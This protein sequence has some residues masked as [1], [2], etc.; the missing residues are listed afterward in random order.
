M[1]PVAIL[2]G[3]L[4]TRLRPITEELPKAL[5]EVG[6]EPFAFRQLAWLAKQGIGRVVY[7][8]G[9]RA[10]QIEAAVGDGAR[11]G[12]AVTYSRDGPRLLGTGGAL[13]QAA[14]RLGEHF[15]VLYGDTFAP[16]DLRAVQ[17]AFFASGKPALM[18]VLKN[19][20]RW[21]R[22]NVLYEDGTLIAYDK[23]APRAEMRH[24]D[25]GLGVLARSVLEGWGKRAAFDLADLYRGLSLEG[26]LAGFEVQGRFYEI[27]SPQGLKEAEAYFLA[28]G[29]P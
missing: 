26:R 27:G 25:Y 29:A 23:R 7:C 19:E 12:L 16:C 11:F 5:V 15:F 1:L 4:A 17:E 9:H 22:S 18:T 3:G 8:V 2:A 21:D 28:E 6:G 20:N 24:I 14:P 10:E 13:R